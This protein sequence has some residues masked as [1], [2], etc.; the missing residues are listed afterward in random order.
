MTLTCLLT[1]SVLGQKPAHAVSV[2]EAVRLAVVHSPALHAVAHRAEAVEDQ[3]RSL[4]G[5][6]LP[7]IALSDEH[8]R[9]SEAFTIAFGPASFNARELN[10]NT[11]VAAAQQPVLGLLHLWQDKAALDDSALAAHEGERITEDAIAEAVQTGYLRYFEAKAAHDVATASIAQLDEQRQVTE[12]RVKAGAATTADVLRLEVAIANAR[13]QQIL[14][15]TQQQ[16]TSSALVL[17]M[18][19]SAED[20]EVELLEPTALEAKQP[21][22]LTEVEVQRTAAATR[23]E[24]IRASHEQRAAE[25]Q[26]TARLFSLLPEANL[27]A[28]YVHIFGQAFA[29]PDSYYVGV[30][31]SWPIWEWGASWYQR[32]AAM[33]SAEAAADLREDQER[34]VKTEASSRLATFRSSKSAVEVAQ[35]AIASAEEAWRVTQ[36]L[37]KAG[38]ATTTDLL[39]AQSALTQ[40][41]LNLVRAKYQQAVA[42]VALERSLGHAP[43]R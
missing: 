4:R 31:A 11:F 43:S 36:A 17:A 28:G 6:M 1:M 35:T 7:G 8:Q 18:G 24:V 33:R 30:K 14:A 27:E 21:P 2:E 10:A 23:P 20:G 34:Q 37:L 32:Q 16:V 39:D 3:A 41:R 42:A 15:Q 13:Q 26:A 40:A 25:H 29:P 22:P 19:L 5:R 9:Y 38:S 12:A